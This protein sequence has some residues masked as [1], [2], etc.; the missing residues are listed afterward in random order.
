MTKLLICPSECSAVPFLARTLP[1]AN[2]PLLG[3]SLLEYWLSALAIRG[4]TKV[5]IL[6][7][8]R[9]ERVMEQVG[10]G[11]RW[12][13]EATVIN[14]SRELTAAEALLKYEPKLGGAAAADAIEVLDHF[15]GV[16]PLPLFASYQAWFAALCLWMPSAQTPDRVGVNESRPKMWKGCR[17]HVSPQAE[18]RPPCWIGQHVFIGT[19]AVVGPQAIVEDGSFVEPGA[20]LAESWVGPDTFVGQFARIRGS[21]A[22]GSTLVN[23]HTGSETQ[24]ADPFLLCSLREPRHKHT[25]GWLKKLSGLYDRNKGDVGVSWKHL[26]LHKQG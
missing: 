4:V 14:E 15:P 23:W 6:A 22:W 12:G 20:E 5:L 11:E 26:L 7:H 2:V 3:Q 21:L 17:C 18:L 16:S 19:G 10:G 1:L 25:P 9:P 13:I 8:D 24:I